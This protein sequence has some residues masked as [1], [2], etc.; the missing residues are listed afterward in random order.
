MNRTFAAAACVA[1]AASAVADDGMWTFDHPPVDLVKQRYGVALTPE[2]LGRLQQAAVN[3][4]ASAA[5]VSNNGL[6]LT[7]HHVAM[8]CVEQL[9][10]RERNLTSKGYLARSAAQE[11]RCPGDMARVLLSTSDVTATVLKAVAGGASDEQRN[12][13]RKSTIAE[14]ETRC[15]NA[16]GVRCE[17]V[18]LYSGSLFHLYR[19]KQWEDVR[20]VF[21]PEY[22]AGFFGGDPD[23]FV[24]PRFALDFA[25]MRVYE[26][27]RPLRTPQHLKLADQPVAEGEPVFVAG[28]PGETDRLQTGAQLKTLRDAVMPLELAS[29]QAQQAL[30]HA[31]SNRSPEAARQALDRLSGTE[32]WLKSLRGEHAALKDPAL[33]AQKEADEARFR[34]AYAER[35]LK[36][37]PWAEIEAAT[38]RHAARA[39][40]LWAVGYGYRTLF[41]QAGKLVELAYERRQPEAERLASYRDAA[42]ADIE[43]QIKADAPVYKELEVARLA[44]H[45]KEARDLLGDHHPYVKVTLAGLAP[46]AAAER[47]LRASRLDDASV[48]ATLLAGG[49]KAIEASDDPLVRLARE[50]YP[51]R[52]ELARFREEQVDT[53][54]QQAAERLGQARFALYGRDSPPDATSTLR[55][56][57]GK[58]A[59]YQANGNTMP[60][61]TTFG[62]LLARA[63][64]FDGKPP[65]DL[66]PSIA[67][68]RSRLDPRVPLNFVTT[69][70]IVGGNSGSP[71]VNRRGEWVGVIFDTNLE[72]LGGRFAYTDA[73]ARSLAVH[74]QGIVHAL[75][76]VY[77]ARTLARELRGK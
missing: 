71:V 6:M 10:T 72:A 64:S 35:G 36:G 74:A 15:A 77:G 66:P 51:L 76:R 57:Y 48:R 62:G 22:Q 1:M 9:S 52:R 16:P 75:E 58:V 45:L 73:Q 47:W 32:N 43:R 40:A 37:N 2:M 31:Y 55:L 39:K 14:L 68:A 11:L 50:V 61:K 29:A 69:A 59:G 12:A 30:L 21:T 33:M 70:D 42:L 26:N 5:F 56:A 53:P 18:S 17:V 38:T 65:F 13:L 25:L 60:W 44:G 4:G 63:D 3:Y 41:D 49:V 34:A 23:N 46:D 8:S 7:N 54:I 24:Y 28:H 67:S 20:L 19:F 27:G